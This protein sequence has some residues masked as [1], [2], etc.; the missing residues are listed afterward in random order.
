MMVI[1]V[2]ALAKHDKQDGERG[3][4]GAQGAAVAPFQ[5]N[6]VVNSNTAKYCSSVNLYAD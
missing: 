5:S 4:G 6:L 1:A 2:V 3:G